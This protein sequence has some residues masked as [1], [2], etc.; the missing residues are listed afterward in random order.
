M[1]D[2]EDDRDKPRGK[3]NKWSQFSR[4]QLSR[5]ADRKGLGSASWFALKVGMHGEDGL[6]KDQ[7][8]T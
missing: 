2:K 8:T 3:P 1:T 5:I 7:S 4:A 6:L